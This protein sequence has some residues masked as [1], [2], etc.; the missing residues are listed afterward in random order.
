MHRPIP[1]VLVIFFVYQLEEMMDWY[2]GLGAPS[3]EQSGVIGVV[4]TAS[5]GIFKFY[6][7]TDNRD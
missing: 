3:M 7:D 1:I 2:M 4:F 5:A 6:V